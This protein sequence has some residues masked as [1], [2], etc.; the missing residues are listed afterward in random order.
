MGATGTEGAEATMVGAVRGL[1]VVAIG[2][3]GVGT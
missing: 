3:G 1:V 2:A